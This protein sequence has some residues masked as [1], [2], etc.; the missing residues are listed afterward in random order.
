MT[1]LVV[2]DGDDTLWSTEALYDR[3]RDQARHAAESAGLDGDAWED[4]ERRIDVEN[5]AHLGLSQARFPTSCVQALEAVA[6]DR[7]IDDALRDA[8]WAAAAAVFEM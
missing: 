1:S 7:L 3:A 5:V 4:A 8:V 6:G 2:F